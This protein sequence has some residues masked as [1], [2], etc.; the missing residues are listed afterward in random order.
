LPYVSVDGDE[1]SSNIMAVDVTAQSTPC[2]ATSLAG[3]DAS[4]RQST[5]FYCPAG[6]SPA[7]KVRGADVDLTQDRLYIVRALPDAEIYVRSAGDRKG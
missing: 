7:A 2:Y 3:A 1:D 6:F 4:S 5:L